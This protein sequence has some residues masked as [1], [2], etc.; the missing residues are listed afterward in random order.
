MQIAKPRQ[1]G[2]A[3]SVQASLLA[4]TNA[5]QLFLVVH[6]LNITN[7]ELVVLTKNLN[8]DFDL[9]ESNKWICT[10]GYNH[11]GVTYEGHL[12]VPSVYDF[13]PVTIKPNEEAI[14]TQLIERNR[15]LKQ[16]TK[17]TQMTVYYAI[18]PEWG[19]RFSSWIGS[20]KSK[21]FVPALKESH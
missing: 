6:L 12:I 3:V 11:P 21:S 20:A 2:L 8:C 17:E 7:R 4:D 19:S 15:S 16:I 10:L 5:P 14:I 1:N 9:I 13:S 18:S